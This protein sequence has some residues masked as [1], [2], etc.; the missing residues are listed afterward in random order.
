M[1]LL[2]AC[3]A[4]R[5]AYNQAPDWTYWWLDGYVD[6]SDE[7][8]PRVREAV[9]AWFKWHRSTQLPDYAALLAQ[10]RIQVGETMTPAQ[11]C[12]WTDE[13]TDRIDRAVDHAIP[14]LAGSVRS[15]SA[16]QLRHLERKFEKNNQTYMA[17]YLQSSAD[18]RT[19]A[20]VK[21]VAERAEFFF[22]KL[23]AGQRERLAQGVAESPFDAQL[24]FAERKLRQ[25]DIVQTLRRL[26]TQPISDDETQ[27]AL[28]AL[29]RRNVSSPRP[30][31]RAYQLRLKDYNCSFAAQMHKLSTSEQR[32]RAAKQFRLWEEDFRSLAADN[33]R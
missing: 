4:L 3:S 15:L 26:S 21:R 7:Q 29:F 27:A 1:L 10:A 32:R 12:Q 13:L 23:D 16:Q 9:V 19:K 17:E 22:G 2:S 30:S 25:Q 18:E 11:I 31:Y 5:I 33:S 14:A 8:S 24:W 6:F 20:Q 28:K